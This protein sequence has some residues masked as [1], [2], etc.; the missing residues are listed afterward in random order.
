MICRRP[1][2]S[3]HVPREGH[4]LG[5]FSSGREAQIISIHVPR[6]GHDWDFL[7]RAIGLW[8]FQS[9][10]PARGTTNFYSPPWGDGVI[11]IHVPREGHDPTRFFPRAAPKPH[12][13]PRAPRG[14]R[15]RRPVGSRTRRRFQST[16]PARGTTQITV[17]FLCCSQF[18]ST[19]PARGTT[20]VT[21]VLHYAGNISIH[22]PREGHDR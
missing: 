9:T 20:L 5:V 7:Q 1:V 12:F 2:I 15:L 17:V 10:C 19:C 8:S 18:Q 14:A 22:V 4:D 21:D 3:I 13:N 11:S 6:E 16:C